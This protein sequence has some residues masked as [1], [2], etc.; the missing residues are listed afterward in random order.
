MWS[1]IWAPKPRLLKSI[2]DRRDFATRSTWIGSGSTAMAFC[3]LNYCKIIVK[4]AEVKDIQ[5]KIVHKCIIL[6]I[7]CISLV[8]NKKYQINN[9]KI[10]K[11]NNKKLNNKIKINKKSI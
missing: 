11:E 4:F 5:R 10:L 2:P 3:F 7:S 6:Q 8:S 1:E 9:F